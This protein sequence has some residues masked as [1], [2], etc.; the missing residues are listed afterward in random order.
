MSLHL[1]ISFIWHRMK[2]CKM[3]EKI[4]SPNCLASPQSLILLGIYL[5]P[6]CLGISLMP[7]LF[8]ISKA[9]SYLTPPANPSCLA[10][11]KP[12]L[13][14]ISQNPTCLA[15]LKGQPYL[16]PPKSNCWHSAYSNYH[17]INHYI[18]K[19]KSYPSR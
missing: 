7:S 18:L 11:R 10:S 1:C 5:K 8:S 3:N 19:R 12:I 17:R 4:Q 14:G 6:N 2:P 13:L 15:P 16:A 9:Q